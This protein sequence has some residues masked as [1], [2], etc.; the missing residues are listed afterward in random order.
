MAKNLSKE[1]RFA[2]II[3]ASVTEFLEK[4][5]EGA[6]M[7]SIASRAGLSKGGLYHHFSSKDEILIAANQVYMQPIFVFINEANNH[8]NSV[9]GLKKYINR[10]LNHWNKHIKE[11]EF[12]FLSLTKIL[13]NE[14]MWVEIE[15]YAKLMTSFLES[16]FIKGIIA[17][18]LKKHDT[19]SRAIALFSA[20]DGITV[21]LAMSNN[22][23]VEQA[24]SHFEKV[25]ID[26]I[27]L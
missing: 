10:Y 20:L 26:E 22:F 1:E 17:G 8:S 4:G 18:K 27:L 25:F 23:T 9:D 21:Y 14:A 16:L 12:T 11:L 19:M 6:S 24:I 2:D 3:N 5:Y 7:N 13:N 15:D